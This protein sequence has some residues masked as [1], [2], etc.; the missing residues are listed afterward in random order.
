[1]NSYYG[2][3]VI[4]TLENSGNCITLRTF[5]ALH[6]RSCRMF[7]D[8]DA[9]YRWLEQSNDSSFM[10]YDCGSFAVM[11]KRNDIVHIHQ[12]WVQ[13][14][15]RNDICGYTQD[16]EL[17]VDDLM[18]V[19]V[20]NVSI[21]KLAELGSCHGSASI[22]I[23]NGAHRQVR[24][25]DHLHRRALIKSMRD[26]FRWKEAHVCLYA[27][28]DKDFGFVDQRVTGGLCLHETHVIG[29]DGK[30]HRKLYYQLHT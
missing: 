23:T 27:D 26:S 2:R 19:V 21:R 13:S 30:L 8:S 7:V 15:Y 1:M 5:D 28:F 29:R 17:F 16:F 20:A 9:L 18:A 4:V 6:G 24:N 12:T 10:D 3:H 25:L 11:H 14:D 22:V